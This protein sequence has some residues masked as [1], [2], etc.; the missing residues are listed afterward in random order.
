[1]RLYHGYLGESNITLYVKK[2]KNKKQNNQGFLTHSFFKVGTQEGTT[3]LK[4]LYKG[5]GH[6]DLS[7]E[8][9]TP[10][11]LRNKS[12]GLVPKIQTSLNSWD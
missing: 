6:R 9:F 3:P 4:S 8:Q 1:M 10:S 2:T 11:I 12:Q 7:H 5:T